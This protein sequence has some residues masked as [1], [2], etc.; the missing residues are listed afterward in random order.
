MQTLLPEQDHENALAEKPDSER[1]GP[2]GPAQLPGSG[3]R[4]PDRALAQV[5]TLAVQMPCKFLINFSVVCGQPGDGG[6]AVLSGVA[7]KPEPWR[8]SPSLSGTYVQLPFRRREVSW[9]RRT[10]LRTRV[11]WSGSC[12]WLLS[13]QMR[14]PS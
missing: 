8:P 10:V 6:G 4:H 11:V 13:S 14:P 12:C 5:S 1:P 2:D 7:E 9:V 3:N